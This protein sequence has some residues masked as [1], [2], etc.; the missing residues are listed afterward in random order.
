MDDLSADAP[1]A[2]L[3]GPDADGLGDALA[4]EGVAVTRVDGVP[5]GESLAAAGVDDAALYVLTDTA[6]AT[7]VP[8]AKERNPEVRA[9]VY[10]GETLPEFAQP[11]TDLAVDPELLDAETVAEELAADATA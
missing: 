8:V 5:T 7:S 10:A 6:E 11:I 9:V 2:V 3:A 1:T 4:A